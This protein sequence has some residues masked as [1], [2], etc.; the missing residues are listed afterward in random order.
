M[1]ATP[2]ISAI[3]HITLTVTDIERSVAWYASALNMTR[4]RDMTGPG[5]IR[6]LMVGDGVM[7]G[8]QQHEATAPGDRFSET[9]VGLDHLSIACADR[10]AVAA[11]LAHLDSVGIRH[12]EISDP[13]ANVATTR[14]P[15]GIAIEFFAPR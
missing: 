7:L 15:D 2:V 4:L 6:T 11:W 3:S 12:S 14:D 10:E 9:R 13:P 5:W 1:T 8:L